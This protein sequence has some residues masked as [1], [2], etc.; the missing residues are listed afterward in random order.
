MSATNTADK[1]PVRDANKQILT[2][3]YKKEGSS[4]SYV[5][6]GGGGHVLLAKGTTGNTMVQRDAD[7]IVY[8]KYFYTEQEDEAAGTSISSVYIKSTD[9]IIRR[10]SFANFKSALNI[11]SAYTLPT[12]SSTTLGGIKVGAGLSISN[13]VLSANG[14]GTADSVHG[15]T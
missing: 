8:G 1:I 14:G 7:G 15:L 2:S 5:L 3:G 11:P 12:A 13:G 9:K 10:V 4:D 6:L